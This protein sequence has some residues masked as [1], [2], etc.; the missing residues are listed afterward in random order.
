M[1][2]SLQGIIA[3][4]VDGMSIHTI[5]MYDRLWVSD[6]RHSNRRRL[7]IG[8]RVCVCVTGSGGYHSYI[9]IRV[10]HFVYQPRTETALNRSC[11]CA[12]N[13]LYPLA[14]FSLKSLRRACPA[15]PHLDHEQL[16]HEPFR[17]K[18]ACLAACDRCRWNYNIPASDTIMMFF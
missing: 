11:F 9:H 15:R 13:D 4:D 1:H 8:E 7:Y 6:K 5:R 12:T 17:G 2:V 16:F 10:L 3:R 18:R 14:L